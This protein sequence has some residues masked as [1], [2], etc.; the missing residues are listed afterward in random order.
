MIPSENTSTDYTPL[1]KAALELFF[2][3]AYF[4]RLVITLQ[5]QAVSLIPAGQHVS[6][7]RAT[8]WSSSSLC[9]LGEG[10]GARSSVEPLETWMLAD[11]FL[12]LLDRRQ[13]RAPASLQAHTRRNASR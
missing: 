5:H 7:F 1:V 2:L 10:G 9:I 11:N 13:S 3:W 8:I 4:T 6:G 12:H